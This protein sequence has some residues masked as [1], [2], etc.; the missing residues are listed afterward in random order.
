MEVNSGIVRRRASFDW[1]QYEQT[2]HVLHVTLFTRVPLV[3]N[4]QPLQCRGR[5]LL[6]RF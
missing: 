3:S 2:R 1:L 4:C 5:A 6:I